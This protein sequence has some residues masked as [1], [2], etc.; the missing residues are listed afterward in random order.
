MLTSALPTPLAQLALP[1]RPQ[2]EDK[3]FARPVLKAAHF[4]TP[5]ATPLPTPPLK[6]A[7]P[8]SPTTLS[9]TALVL[10]APLVS[11]HTEDQ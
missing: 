10:L 3:L 1:A 7:R 9:T 4:A 11:S 2:L 6:S 8:A 5:L